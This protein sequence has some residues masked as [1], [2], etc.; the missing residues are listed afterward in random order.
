MIIRLLE[1]L[2]GAVIIIPAMLLFGEVVEGRAFPNRHKYSRLMY[3]LATGIEI[4]CQ[5]TFYGFILLI[6]YHVAL[7]MIM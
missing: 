2:I 7:A 1:T 3:I 6:I 5:L 4:I